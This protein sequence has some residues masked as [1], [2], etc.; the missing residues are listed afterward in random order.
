[1]VAQRVEVGVM[2]QPVA[3]ADAGLDRLLEGVGPDD[4][5]RLGQGR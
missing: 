3:V 1:M 2:L 4:A 5:S